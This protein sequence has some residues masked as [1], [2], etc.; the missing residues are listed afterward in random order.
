MRFNTEMTR[1]VFRVVPDIGL[2]I[3]LTLP[4][5]LNTQMLVRIPVALNMLLM[6]TMEVWKMSMM[7][8]SILFLNFNAIACIILRLQKQTFV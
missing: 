5:L 1:L 8:E 7:R 3:V 4:V 2:I 6:N